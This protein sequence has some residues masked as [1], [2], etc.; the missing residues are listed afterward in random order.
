MDVG[1][2]ARVPSLPWINLEIL[3]FPI[4]AFAKKVVLLPSP[5]LAVPRKI[6]LA[7]REKIHQGPPGNKILPMAMLKRTY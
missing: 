4:K 7:A 3:C 5:V 2:R 1:R 6:F